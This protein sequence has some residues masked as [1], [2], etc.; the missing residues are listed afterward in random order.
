MHN[1]DVL[2]YIKRKRRLP[3]PSHYPPQIAHLKLPTSNCPPQIYHLLLK[4]WSYNSN[5][6]PTFDELANEIKKIINILEERYKRFKVSLNMNYVNLPAETKCYDDVDAIK[7]DIQRQIQQ[8][9]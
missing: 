4:C 3:C 7:K 2:N 6:R 8:S 5:D 1:L 9:N